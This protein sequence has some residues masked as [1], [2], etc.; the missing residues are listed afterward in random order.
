MAFILQVTT[1][2]SALIFDLFIVVASDTNVCLGIDPW[3]V[4]SN[5]DHVQAINIPLRI[6]QSLVHKCFGTQVFLN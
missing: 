6:A 4:C 3:V 1:F 5:K 2:E